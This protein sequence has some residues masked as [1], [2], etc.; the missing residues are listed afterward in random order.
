LAS[1]IL[2]YVLMAAGVAYVLDTMARGLLTDYQSVA[3]VFLV[4]VALP[5]MVGE[6]WLGLWLLLTK[7]LRA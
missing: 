1:K 5:S 7:R 4:V 6:A 3:S 2:G